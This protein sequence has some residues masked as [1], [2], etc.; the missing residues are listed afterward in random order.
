MSKLTIIPVGRTD[1]NYRE[2]S[3]T[4]NLNRPEG[5]NFG[6]TDTDMFRVVAG[7]VLT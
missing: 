7:S 6:I 5:F 1:P 3:V 2:A 4:M